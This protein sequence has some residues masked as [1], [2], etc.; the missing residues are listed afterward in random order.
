MRYPVHILAVFFNDSSL[1]PSPSIAGPHPDLFLDKD[2]IAWIKSHPNVKVANEMDW[3]PF[4]FVDGE[5]QKVIP[6]T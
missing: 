5:S 1:F 3:P 4:D 6:L 2:E